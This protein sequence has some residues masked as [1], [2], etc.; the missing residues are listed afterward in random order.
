MAENCC[1][2][3]TLASDIWQRTLATVPS[4][5]SSD[6]HGTTADNLWDFSS[7]VPAGM[8]INL[9]TNDQVNHRPSLIPVFN[10]TYLSLI[11]DTAAAYTKNGQPA[12]HFFLAVGPMSSS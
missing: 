10:M 12:P 1:G 4:S 3:S 5:N 7:W 8:V 11:V 2:G 6:P 9:G